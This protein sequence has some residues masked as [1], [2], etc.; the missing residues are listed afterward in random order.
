[1]SDTAQTA[2]PVTERRGDWMLTSTGRRFW[3]LDPRPEDIDIEDIATALTHVARYGGQTRR[4]YSVAQHSVHLA[5]W[6]S[7]R[8]FH[9]LAPYA[10]LHDAAEAY[11]GDVIRPIKPELAG[12][13]AIEA[14]LEAM[15]LERFGLRGPIPAEVKDADTRIIGDEMRYLFPAEALA[16]QGLAGRPRLGL[17]VADLAPGVVRALFLRRF[18]ALFPEARR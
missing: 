7:A 12:Y 18:A 2:Q 17:H 16:A 13:G 10:L 8:H 4:H 11:L 6:F 9:E 1:M 3:P 15:I 5:D 14:R